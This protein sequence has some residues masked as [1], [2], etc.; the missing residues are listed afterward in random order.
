MQPIQNVK[1]TSELGSPK[2]YATGTHNGKVYVAHATCNDG[3]EWDWDL[4]T[5]LAMARL[6]VQVGHD[7]IARIKA[8]RRQAKAEIERLEALRDSLSEELYEV[9]EKTEEAE[10]YIE[11]LVESTY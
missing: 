8:I 3:D 4:G 7:E 5:K 11:D 6:A 2:L 10:D 9:E 1:I